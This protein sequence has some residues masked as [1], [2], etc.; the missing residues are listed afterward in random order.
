MERRLV[1]VYDCPI[2]SDFEEQIK[3]VIRKHGWELYGHG[4]DQY[5]N[6]RDLEFFKDEGDDE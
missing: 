1:I 3:K 5:T 6:E 2:E 4:F